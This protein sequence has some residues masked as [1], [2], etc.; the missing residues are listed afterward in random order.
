M[1]ASRLTAAQGTPTRAA[2]QLRL[3][4]APSKTVAN[5]LAHARVSGVHRLALLH[6]ADGPARRY[7]NREPGHT[8]LGCPRTH[9]GYLSSLW[10]RR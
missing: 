7:G 8:R 10:S 4:H 9:V 1:R 5:G 3:A 6:R 2:A